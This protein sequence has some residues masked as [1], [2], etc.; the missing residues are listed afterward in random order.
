MISWRDLGE[1]GG[2]EALQVHARRRARAWQKERE[3]AEAPELVSFY[4]TFYFNQ[5]ISSTVSK[6]YD[7]RVFGLAKTKR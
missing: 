2:G 5:N 7:K 1:R 4:A 3:Q 6:T